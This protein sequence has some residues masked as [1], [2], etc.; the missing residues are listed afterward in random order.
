MIDDDR[1]SFIFANLIETDEKHSK[2]RIRRIVL[3]ARGHQS[4]TSQK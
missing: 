2:H 4:K 1:D 3:V